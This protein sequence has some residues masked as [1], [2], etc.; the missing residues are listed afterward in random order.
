MFIDSHCHLD[1]LDLVDY[2]HSLENLLAASAASNVCKML[3][4]STSL[5]SFSTMYKQ[6]KPFSQIDSSMGVHPLEVKCPADVASVEQ[7]ISLAKDHHKVVAIGESGLD[8]YY[9]SDNKE[10]QK[11]SFINHLK[12]GT[13]LDLPVIVHTRQAREDTIDLIDSH[14]GG[15]AGVL[16]CFT[17]SLEMAQ[18]AIELDYMISISGI[19]TFKNSSELK[20]VVKALPLE[21]ILIETDAP[22]LAPMPYRGK[23]NQPKYVVEVAQYIADLKCVSLAELAEITTDNYYSLFKNSHRPS[24]N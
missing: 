11:Q 6:I 5:A 17:E 3:C 8:Y 10:V 22:Y 14:G 12:V 7:L 13:A 4:V 1:K 15:A 2:N 19:V 23:Q 20:A 24:S 18:Q 16:H 9:D 21:R